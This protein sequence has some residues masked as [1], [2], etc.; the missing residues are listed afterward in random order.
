[1]PQ[2]DAPTDISTNPTTPVVPENSPTDTFVA[3][4]STSDPDLG[5]EGDA[6]TYTM[7]NSA[8]G[9][10]KIVGSQ[11]RVDN[12]TLLDFETATSHTIRVRTTDLANAFFEKDF[13]IQVSDVFEPIGDRTIPHTQ[14]QLTFNLSSTN[15]Y[16]IRNAGTS[17]WFESHDLNLTNTGI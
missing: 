1:N 5:R 14:N 17:A 3:D 2:D 9:R 13:T 7:V 16:Q 12:G 4:L 10:F 6:F 11:I 8:G 15:N